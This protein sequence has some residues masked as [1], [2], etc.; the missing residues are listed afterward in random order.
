VPSDAKKDPIDFQGDS[1]YNTLC[2]APPS[3]DGTLT[4]RLSEEKLLKRLRQLGNGLFFVIMLDDEPV[5]AVVGGK[6]E[7][8]KKLA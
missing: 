4:L 8:L 3:K 7:I 1:C 5:I 2:Q 6:A